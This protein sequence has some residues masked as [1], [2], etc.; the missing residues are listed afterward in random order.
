MSQYSFPVLPMPKSNEHGIALVGCGGIGRMQLNAYRKAGW[1]VV[2]LCDVSEAAATAAKDE[3]FPNAIATTDYAWVLARTDVTVVDLAVHTNIRPAMVRQAILAGK[4]VMS[5]K[6]FVERLEEGRELAE[7]A[8]EHGVVLAVNQ[9]GRWAPHFLAL[10][11][12]V[13]SGHLGELVAADF[14]AYWPHDVHTEHHVLGQDPNL[15]LYDYAIHWFDLIANLFEDHMPRSVYAITTTRD[16]QKIPVPTIATV[17]IDYGIAQVTIA[18]RAS[19]RHED[20]GSYH[21]IGT[22]GAAVLYGSPLDG[23]RVDIFAEPMGSIEIPGSWFPDALIGSMADLLCSIENGTLPSAHPRSSL[24][25]LALCFAAI[26]SAAT[27]LPVD[28]AT[29]NSLFTLESAK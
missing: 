8:E 3:Y 20:S 11:E 14:A 24:K 5:Q 23:S 17:V 27:G 15:V 10:R 22:Q 25:G 16:G 19:A 1:N 7:L 12:I 6:P 29:V 9:N 21:V 4:H 18:M 13:K 26:E 28:P 2:V